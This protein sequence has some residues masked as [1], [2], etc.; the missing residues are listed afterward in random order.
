MSNY[1]ANPLYE[2]CDHYLD[3]YTLRL[4]GWARQV[5]ATTYQLNLLQQFEKGAASI[6]AVLEAYPFHRQTSTAFL[7]TCV[8]EQF[9]LPAGEAGRPVFPDVRR[10]ENTIFNAPHHRPDAPSA[11]T[12][13]GIPFDGNTTG[14]PGARFGPSSVRAASEGCRYGLSPATLQPRGFIDFSSGRTVLAG[15][16]MSDAGD[17]YLATG[18]EPAETYDRITN[19]AYEVFESGTIPVFLGGDHSITYPILRAIPHD[20][21]GVIHFDAHTDLGD[22]EPAG[23]HHG[24][25]FSLV[26]QRLEF[27]T[28]IH[29]IGLR[30]LYEADPEHRHPRV[31]WFGVDRVRDEPAALL[32]QIPSDK[33]YYLSVDIDVVDPAF[34][35]ST[36]TPVAGGLYPHELKKM[37]RAVC[38][39]RTV[40]GMDIVEVGPPL[41]SADSTASVAVEAI[42]AMAGGLVDR[43]SGTDAAE[44]TKE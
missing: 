27:V 36:G 3:R 39:A 14:A 44:V 7:E 37:I 18:E 23:L 41:N 26:L 2:I 19:A 38:A 28:S 8:S 32:D 12:F 6:G 33:P 11:F 30:G 20:E 5:E 15:V 31:S 42:M 25:V 21:I 29:Q 17:V 9:L 13:M 43:L 24:N 22:I 34:A 35:P 16:T 40:V 1:V 10:V 4:P